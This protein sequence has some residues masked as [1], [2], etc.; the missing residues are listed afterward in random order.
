MSTEQLYVLEINSHGFSGFF[1]AMDQVS[2]QFRVNDL[3]HARR[4]NRTFV[5]QAF[6]RCKERKVRAR[7]VTY[8]NL[9]P[10]TEWADKPAETPLTLADNWQKGVYRDRHNG[11]SLEFPWTLNRS[12]G[13]YYCRVNPEVSV[14]APSLPALFTRLTTTQ[15]WEESLKAFEVE[16]LAA[17]LQ[18]APIPIPENVPTIQLPAGQSVSFSVRPGSARPV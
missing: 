11:R 13:L 9:D 10:V 12:L 4:M 17:A 14:S 18:P 8:P 1:E 7:A 2:N 15:G 16:D 3:Q 5:E 6:D